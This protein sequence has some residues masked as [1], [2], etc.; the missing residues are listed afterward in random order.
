[1]CR[2]AL[3]EQMGCD[4]SAPGSAVKGSPELFH[5]KVLKASKTAKRMRV[6]TVTMRKVHTP[7][8]RKASHGVVNLEIA[9][10]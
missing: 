2:M 7:F 4:V 9:G 10:I 5:V 1:M 8:Q 6:F 3:F